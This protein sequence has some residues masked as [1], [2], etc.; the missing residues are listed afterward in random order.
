MA[1]LVRGNDQDCYFS[2]TDNPE[3]Q[4]I[5]KILGKPFLESCGP[6]SASMLVFARLT[7]KEAEDYYPKCKGSYKPQPESVLYDYFHDPVNYAELE[8]HRPI[9]P[10]HWCGNR[11]PQWY[12]PALMGVFG[13]KATFAWGK[14]YKSIARNISN[15]IGV[16]LCLKSPGHFIAVVGCNPEKKELIYNDPWP[17]NWW[18][19]RLKGTSPF[20][21][22]M[23]LDELRDNVRE[24][25]VLVG[26]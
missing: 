14:N 13:V 11:I 23:R 3:E 24:F 19:Q 21:R 1:F 22:I 15:N 16:M 25:V 9:N 2:Q 10:M 20:N 17:E 26:I 5:S 6:T 7:E 12:T 8:R 18:P 4:A